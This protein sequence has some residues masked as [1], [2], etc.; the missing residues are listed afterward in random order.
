MGAWAQWIDND[1]R[2]Y[3]RP[4]LPESSFLLAP[5]RWQADRYEPAAAPLLA[6]LWS[7][8]WG[9]FGLAALAALFLAIGGNF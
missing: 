6:R 3:R 7:R 2:P 4:D 5:G 1:L 9:M 8:F